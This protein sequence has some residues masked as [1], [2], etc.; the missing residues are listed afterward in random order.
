MLGFLKN[1]IIIQNKNY[2]EFYTANHHLIQNITFYSII[3]PQCMNPQE[4]HLLL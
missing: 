3:F 1:N 2:L 4:P